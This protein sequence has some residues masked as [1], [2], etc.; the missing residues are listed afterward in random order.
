[1]NRSTKPLLPPELGRLAPDELLLNETFTSIQGESTHAGRPCFFIRLTGCHIRC[2]WCDTEYA[3][4]EGSVA[5]VDEC[6]TRAAAASCRLVE[7]TGGEP[8]LQKSAFTLLSRLCDQGYEVLVET[9]GAIDIAGVDPRVGRI[10]DWKCPG[11]GMA[12][13]NLESV[14]DDL[15][16]GDELKLVIIDRSDYTWARDFVREFRKS[17]RD[18]ALT[19]PIHFSPVSDRLNSRDLSAWILEDGIEVRLNLQLHKIIW[20]PDARGV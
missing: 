10:V 8:L 3:F 16:E 2:S 9:S 6:L 4:H 5:T 1:M 14:L 7:L 12:D 17:P 11:S 13:R 19:I 20:S 15:R 18:G